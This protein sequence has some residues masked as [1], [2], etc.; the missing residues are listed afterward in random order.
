MMWLL[1]Y[2]FV[3]LTVFITSLFRWWSEFI[4]C[5]F[6]LMMLSSA[7]SFYLI[8]RSFIPSILFNLSKQ[9]LLPFLLVLMFRCF[10]NSS[11]RTVTFAATEVFLP[12]RRNFLLGNNLLIVPLWNLFFYMFYYLSRW[13]PNFAFLVF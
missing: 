7:F 2:H 11:M 3:D 12:S 8:F 4:S 1:F 6:I 5:S 10:D 9:R 13:F